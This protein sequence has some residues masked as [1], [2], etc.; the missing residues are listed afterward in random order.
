MKM[1]R[2]FIHQRT[3]TEL[4]RSSS[5]EKP[6]PRLVC[7]KDEKSSRF[8]SRE[9]STEIQRHEQKIETIQVANFAMI[10][11]DSKFTTDGI[12]K[13][14]CHTFVPLSWKDYLRSFCWVLRMEVLESLATRTKVTF[15]VNSN[16]KPCKTDR[17]LVTQLHQTLHVDH[18]SQLRSFLILE[19]STAVKIL[20]FIQL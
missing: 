13:I 15:R 4:L 17:D 3:E 2:Q 16:P 1:P 9:V 19:A 20:Q 11:T 7:I 10:L 18:I 12:C 6:T 14:S 5:R 8:S